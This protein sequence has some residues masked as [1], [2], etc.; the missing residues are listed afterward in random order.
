MSGIAR[1]LDETLR[2]IDPRAAERITHLVREILLLAEVGHDTSGLS[3]SGQPGE[4]WML[5]LAASAEPMDVLTN[6]EIDQA[7]YGR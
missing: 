1:E 3:K 6:A 5:D 2:R 7:I 4:V